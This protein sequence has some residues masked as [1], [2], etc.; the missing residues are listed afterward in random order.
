[1]KRVD[2]IRSIEASGC[3]MEASTTGIAIQPRVCPSPCLDIE[4]SRSRWL[5]ESFVSLRKAR[6]ILRPTITDGAQNQAMQRTRDK[7]GR[8]G[9]PM[10]ASR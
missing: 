9:S 6:K 2:L 3:G 4:R 8:C 1:M 7:I 10:V 5:G